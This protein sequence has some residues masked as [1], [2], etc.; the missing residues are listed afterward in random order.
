MPVVDA[1]V[2]L[3]WFLANEPYADL[4]LKLLE[5]GDILIAPDIIVPEVWALSGKA[6][7]SPWPTIRHEFEASLF[8]NPITLMA[9]Q[10]VVD[11]Q[12]GNPAGGEDV[13]LRREGLGIVE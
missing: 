13:H 5:D 3:K 11:M 4:A 6:K 10:V 9:R 12:P 1:S 8:E 7:L 2:A